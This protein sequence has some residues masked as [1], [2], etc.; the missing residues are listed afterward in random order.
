ML[1]VELTALGGAIFGNSE[2]IFSVD[3]GGGPVFLPGGRAEL[4]Q[5]VALAIFRE[6]IWAHER[7]RGT[8][9]DSP[10][11]I[12]GRFGN[13]H[14]VAVSPHI[15]TTRGL[16]SIMHCLVRAVARIG[17]R[18]AANRMTDRMKASSL[19]TSPRSTDAAANSD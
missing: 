7:Q 12:V 5:F 17:G 10:A 4:P 3:Y 8:M 16:E 19:V 18:S 14:A 11:I 2:P 1:K 13:G 9:T 6:E 15:E